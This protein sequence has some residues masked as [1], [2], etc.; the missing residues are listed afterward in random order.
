MHLRR[1]EKKSDNNIFAIHGGG[2][3]GLGLM[4][5]IASKS[6]FN[7]QIRATSN[8]KFVK[9]IVNS[10]HQLS[11][12]H[13][14]NASNVTHIENVTVVSRDFKDVVELYKEATVLAICLTPNA[15]LDSVKAIAQGL[16]QRSQ[17]KRADLNVFVLMNLPDCAEMVR[18]KV[19][20]EIFSQVANT[21]MAKKICASVKF[22]P[23]V[24]DRIVTKISDDDVKKQFKQQL[25][26]CMSVD[27]VDPAWLNKQ[28][29]NLLRDPEKL[30]ATIQKLNF[31]FKLFNA[32][33][34]FALYAPSHVPEV[35]QFPAIKPV[36]DLGK[37]EAIKNKYI[38]GPHA[39]IAWLGGILGC[40]TIADAIRYPGVKQFIENTM[41]NE[42]AVTLLSEYPNLTREELK[43]FKELFLK[44]CEASAEDTVLRVGRDPLRKINGGERIRGTIEISQVHKA[45]IPLS[46]LEFGLAAAIIYAVKQLDPGNPDCQKIREIFDC[47]QSYRDVLSYSGAYSSGNFVGLDPRQNASLI[48]N[49]LQKIT[50]LEKIYE[51]Q[52]QLRKKVFQSAENPYLHQTRRRGSPVN[53]LL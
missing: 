35:L 20:Q 41:D 51:R 38:N 42:I 31:Q 50:T 53:L 34:S 22:I 25:L 6:P 23:T 52:Q 33:E 9:T 39:M 24:V 36:N 7:Y 40:E 17:T 30:T 29:D 19:H 48:T 37:V 16:I 28:V 13:N 18:K 32:E 3:I 27:F 2:N 14:S 21:A 45:R 46:G 15:L 11:L 10:T 47:N 8:N 5:D 26:A 49:V 4:A 44:R 12:Q 1:L 43:F